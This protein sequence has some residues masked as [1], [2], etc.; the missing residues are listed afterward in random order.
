M[1]VPRSWLRGLVCNA[2]ENCSSPPY[3]MNLGGMSRSRW[4][5]VPGPPVAPV[6]G[7]GTGRGVCSIMNTDDQAFKETTFS[8]TRS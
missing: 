2:N 6:P 4:A 5:S 1:S 8:W 3:E 7:H